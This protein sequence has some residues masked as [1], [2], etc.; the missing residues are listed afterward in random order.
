MAPFLGLR[1]AF[2]YQISQHLVF[3]INNAYFPF[4]FCSSAFRHLDPAGT[5]YV[6]CSL[7]GATCRR[8]CCVRAPRRLRHHPA[9]T[10]RLVFSAFP[11]AV[12]YDCRVQTY[13]DI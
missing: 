12:I 1:A 11:P 3:D 2:Q 6:L 8:L 7:R 4:L 5:G 9:V 13:G 10:E